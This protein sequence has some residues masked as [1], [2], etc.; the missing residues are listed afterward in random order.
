MAS[1]A[2][3]LE[4]A[5]KQRILMLNASAGNP[6]WLELPEAAWG[7]PQFESSPNLN[8]TRPDLVLKWSIELLAAGADILETR[9]FGADAFSAAEYGAD[10]SQRREWTLKAVAIAQE[11]SA[12]PT[13]IVGA[14]GAVD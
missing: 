12:G 9:S 8:V 4:H 14:V 1:G 3:P 10:R 5:L 6:A 7:G 11:A 13:F 2:I